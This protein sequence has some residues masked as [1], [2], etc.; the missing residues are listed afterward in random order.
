MNTLNNLSISKRLGGGFGLIVLIIA[1]FGTFV[2]DGFRD[3]EKILKDVD[4]NRIP[5]LIALKSIA[6]EHMTLR[7]QTVSVLALYEFSEENKREL[8]RLQEQRM[9]SLEK[10]EE[11]LQDFESRPRYT[12]TGKQMVRD[13][14]NCFRVDLRAQAYARL[15][16]LVDNLQNARDAMT[17]TSL[18]AEYERAIDEMVPVSDKLNRAVDALWNNNITNT[19]RTSTEGYHLAHQLE[20]A[21]LWVIFVVLTLAIIIA[22]TLTKSVTRPVQTLVGVLNKVKTGDMTAQAPAE[23]LARQDEMGTLSR[24]LQETTLSVQQAM[25]NLIE[26]IQTLSSASTEL[27]AVAEQTTNQAKDLDQRAQTVS[28]A[29]EELSTNVANVAAG[30]EQT[31]TNLSSVASATEEM[32]ATIGEIASNAEKARGTTEVAGQKVEDF[33]RLMRELGNA[34]QE[35]GKV[36][37][38][39]SGISDQTN[40]LAL[41]ATIEAARAGAAGKG[42][43][44]VA[45][46]IKEL[47]QQTAEA[48]EEIKTKI[49]GIQTSSG[50]AVED[51]GNIVRVMREVNEIVNS[52]AAS[53]EEQSSVTREVSGN[54]NEATTGVQDSNQRSNESA[55]A[56][57][58]VSREIS[59][60]TQTASDIAEASNQTNQS[61]QELS[62][63]AETLRSIVSRFKV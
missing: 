27:L 49:G 26:G 47:A 5:D 54:I 11:A 10:V 61:A 37:E 46:E 35:I 2:F 19:R 39:I 51:V 17:Y 25:K 31:S 34:A 6:E 21:T 7:S 55:R 41:N 48:T 18:I 24:A 60:V 40:L 59:S 22:F 13:L 50:N 8:R 58:E 30:M 1:I 33:S 57:A 23:L 43:A 45:N 56:V 32:T 36:T 12:E 29:S 9:A 52:I 38:T 28:A 14:T 44:V 20:G 4:E 42:F 53:V 63:L 62:K 16:D 15:I 3:L